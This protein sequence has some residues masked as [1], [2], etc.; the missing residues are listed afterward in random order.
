MKGRPWVN[1]PILLGLWAFLAVGI[2]AR[3]G[4]AEWFVLTVLTG[5]MLLAV[6]GPLLSLRRVT[7]RRRLSDDVLR[8]GGTLKAELSFHTGCI[9]PFVWIAIREEMVSLTDHA[10]EPV[11]YRRVLLPWLKR[12]FQLQYQISPVRRGEWRLQTITVEAGDLFGLMTRRVRLTCESNVLVLPRL[13][14]GSVGMRLW[15]WGNSVVPGALR[16]AQGAAG[17]DGSLRPGFQPGTGEER[18]AYTYGDSLRYLDWRSVAKGRS[19]QVRKQERAAASRCL[20]VLDGWQEAY[21]GN[22][23][24]FDACIV[25]ALQTYEDVQSQ[26]GEA[27]LYCSGSDPVEL[28]GRA[29]NRSV[30][31]ASVRLARARADGSYNLAALV[32]DSVLRLPGRGMLIW[33]TGGLHHWAEVR[34]LA[35][36]RQCG[37]ELWLI[38]DRKS[39]SHALR[40]RIKSFEQQGG[41]VRLWT[42]DAPVE[43][44]TTAWD[45]EERHENENVS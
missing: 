30:A 4:W 5:I 12:G 11:I 39:P 41:V 15:N 35:A 20:I 18:R 45:G 1:W 3:G 23:A 24:L 44:Q 37:I 42:L 2:Q 26:G 17:A 13:S 27:H 14:E 33:I 29:G 9:L 25:K 19:W 38:T 7:V 10:A 32:S 21:G 28:H 16:S 43:P 34:Q 36:A 8:A 31:A 22:S 6:L 40:D